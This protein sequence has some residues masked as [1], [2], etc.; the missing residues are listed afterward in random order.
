MA[1]SLFWSSFLP[2]TIAKYPCLVSG[3]DDSNI[4]Q[5]SVINAV[6]G[7]LDLNRCS[8]KIINKHKEKTLLASPPS[9][10]HDQTAAVAQGHHEC[11]YLGDN[12]KHREH[13]LNINFCKIWVEMFDIYLKK[14]C[15]LG[16]LS[17]T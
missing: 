5:H 13:I 11:K 12:E 9:E 10:T 17:A 15:Q 16:Q 1:P 4:Y 7:A 14:I 3:Y 6:F 8:C 2:D